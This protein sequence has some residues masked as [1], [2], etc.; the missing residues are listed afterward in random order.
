MQA[1]RSGRQEQQEQHEVE[2]EGLGVP[3][4]IDQL[5]EH[6]LPAADLKKLKDAGG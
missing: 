5:Q 1:A 6:G 2:E 3:F 4:S